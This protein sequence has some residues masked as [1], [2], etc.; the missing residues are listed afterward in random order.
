MKEALRGVGFQETH[1]MH[2]TT[3][4]SYMVLGY[5][6]DEGYEGGVE[7]CGVPGDTAHGPNHLNI[8]PIISPE[9]RAM[10]EALRGV[11]FQETHS[12]H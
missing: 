3:K 12:M 5:E 9:M 4:A 7:R 6:R 10:K 11:G 8:L 1:P 2:R